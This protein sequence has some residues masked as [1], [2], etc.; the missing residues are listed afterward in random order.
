M[1]R[2]QDRVPRQPD[3]PLR[4]RRPDGRRGP[5]RPQDHRRHLRR[6]G[7][8]RRRRV[9]RQGSVQGRPQRRVRGALGGEEPRRGGSR[10]ARRGAARLRDRRGRAGLDPRR[11]VRHLAARLRPPRA[12]RARPLRPHAAR[13][14]RG[15]RSAAPDLP[16]DRLSRPLRARGP[17]LPLGGDVARRR[18]APRGGGGSEQAAR[19]RLQRPS[20]RSRSRGRPPG[21]ELR[22]L[23]LETRGAD[24]GGGCAR[25]ARRRGAA[26]RRAAAW[27]ALGGAGARSA[28]RR[29]SVGAR[30]RRRRAARRRPARDQPR[31]ARDL[32]GRHARLRGLQP[33]ES[34]HAARAGGGDAHLRALPARAPRRGRA[35]TSRPT[36]AI[37]C[38]AAC[39]SRTARRERGRRHALRGADLERPADPRGVPLG[40]GRAHGERGGG[41][42]RGAAV[43]AQRRRRDEEDS[44]DTYWR[45]RYSRAQLAR[46]LDPL[47]L[48]LGDVREARVAARTRERPRRA[49]RA[50]G[51][52]RKRVGHGAR[53]CA[54]RSAT[55]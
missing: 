2:R 48:S 6:H 35:S 38:T 39:A 4:G 47:G 29:R 3:R 15:A 5:H 46:A 33:L 17:G 36:R 13:D 50:H 22:V 18:A 37:R 52:G 11:H 51:L 32:R 30:Q 12:A 7:A 21:E 25:R 28:P 34:R 40:V 20:S 1:D 41:L 23:L 8:P 16:R 43:S 44:P 31:A 53:S 49:R 27:A 42:G 14:H 10:A 26:R 54:P 55:R 24:A 9:L 45:V 19:G